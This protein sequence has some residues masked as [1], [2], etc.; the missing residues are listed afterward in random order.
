MLYLHNLSSVVLET[1]KQSNNIWRKQC[2]HLSLSSGLILNRNE[3]AARKRFKKRNKNLGQAVVLVGIQLFQLVLW[4]RSFKHSR[5]DHKVIW[6]HFQNQQRLARIEEKHL[7]NHWSHQFYLIL[8][9]FILLQWQRFFEKRFLKTNKACEQF[10]DFVPLLAV[11]TAPPQEVTVINITTVSVVL[12]WKPP[13]QK[14]QNGRIRGYKVL[15][16]NS[17]KNDLKNVNDWLENQ[18]LS[19]LFRHNRRK[20]RS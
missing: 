13:P 7:G 11:P 4:D 8:L 20:W 16:S 19:P 1:N 12:Q 14:Q 2:L 10:S 3:T 17:V 18:K 15:E 6:I 5:Q 9:L